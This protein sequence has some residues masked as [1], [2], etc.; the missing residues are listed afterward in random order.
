MSTRHE[1]KNDNRRRLQT[2]TYSQLTAQR[3]ASRHREKMGPG[4]A[5][6][7]RSPLTAASGPSPLGR[8]P[9]SRPVPW[10]R[11]SRRCRLPW[12]LP[13]A[14]E[15]AMVGQG[16]L[17]PPALPPDGKTLSEAAAGGEGGGGGGREELLPPDAAAPL[18]R[19]PPPAGR[20]P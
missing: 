7:R 6:G 5:V 14:P 3:A 1:K 2:S 8:L 17:A 13:S 19:I 12:D 16:W 4:R 9:R 18:C 20:P 10:A 11:P 15:K